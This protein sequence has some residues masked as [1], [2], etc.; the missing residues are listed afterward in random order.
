MEETKNK[1]EKLSY[2]QLNHMAGDLYQ[3]NQQLVARIKQMQEA[4]EDTEFNHLSFFLSMLFKV[5]DHPDS[6]TGDFVVW[7]TES[8]EHMLTGY[9]DTFFK[10]ADDSENNK[11]EN[12][13]DEA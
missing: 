4:L 11:P 3:Q 7:C 10:K 1:Q 5:I 2:E 9:A 8:I 6:Y 13:S 12:K